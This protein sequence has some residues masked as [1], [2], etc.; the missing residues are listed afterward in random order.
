MTVSRLAPGARYMI[1]SAFFFSLMGLTVKLAGKRLPT[2]EIVVARA[3]VTLVLSFALLRRAG[4]SPWGRRH[5]LLLLRGAV[6]FL[7]LLAFYYSL[8]HLP[9]AEATVI[10]HTSPVLTAMFAAL[11]LRER[12]TPRLVVGAAIALAGVALVARPSF[13]FAATGGALPLVPVVIGCAGAILSAIAYVIVRELSHSEDA[14]VI[15][16]YFPLVAVPAS[17]P[18]LLKSF[19]W[20][21][22]W[23][24]LVL[25][26]VGVST[27]IA[28]VC[29]TRALALAPAGQAISLAYL[30]IV[31]ATVFGITLFEE[32]PRGIVVLGAALVVVGSLLPSLVGART[33]AATGE[34]TGAGAERARRRASG[35]RPRRW[36][37][38][39]G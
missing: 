15:V 14:L 1:A 39:R 12:T 36:W 8:T 5:G 18:F 2:H 13:L 20:P 9:L 11:V 29:L 34:A 31:F 23:E 30:Q 38:S 28:Q 21:R 10:H 22:G 37:S 17:L 26:A 33:V 32:V 3:L 4:R 24:W 27:Q 19:V 25:L 7:A 16:F 6:G 35:S